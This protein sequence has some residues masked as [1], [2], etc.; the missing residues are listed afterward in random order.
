L[1]CGLIGLPAVLF[2]LWLGLIQRRKGQ[3]VGVPP[4]AASALTS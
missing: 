3:A 4:T 1:G 2:C